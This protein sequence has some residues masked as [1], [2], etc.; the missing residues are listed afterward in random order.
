MPR[1]IGCIIALAAVLGLS[2]VWAQ[3]PERGDRDALRQRLK[4][5]GGRSDSPAVAGKIDPADSRLYKLPAGPY[6]R[7]VIESFTL[8]DEKRDKDLPLRITV[9]AGDGPCP[10][11][12]YSHGALGSKDGYQPLVEHWASHGYV[13]IQP[14]H[15]D[16]ISLMSDQARRNVRSIRKLVNSAQVKREWRDRPLDIRWV[17]DSL[18]AIMKKAE[19]LAGRID[20]KRIAVA[21]HSYGAYTTMLVAGMKLY[22]P[23]GD[24][25]IQLDDK[26]PICFVAISPQGTSR[27]V[28]AE[29]Y[30]AFDRPMLMITGDNDGTPIEGRTD[31][32]GIWRKEAFDHTPAGDKYLLWI[33]GAE[34]GFGGISG[35]VRFAG[36]GPA[37]PDQV[38]LV[39]STALAFFDAYL[40]GDQA[41]RAYLSS[42]TVK[43]ETDNAAH[44]E[45]KLK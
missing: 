28:R 2:V 17:I 23:G 45:S 18:D 44:V 14:T 35:P 41:A 36:S 16:S 15:G 40:R 31:K 30:H 27:T 5:L 39:R 6:E 32:K 22:M 4:E 8:R 12:L 38:H 7:T 26:R 19:G 9:P 3:T 11:I 37:N 24:R 43:Q 13:V 1:R 10:L 21:G 20:T 42:G 33:D 29:S 34:H 25:S